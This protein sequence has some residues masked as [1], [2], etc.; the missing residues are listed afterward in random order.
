MNS[1]LKYTFT[2]PLGVWAIY[3]GEDNKYVSIAGEDVI[4][5]LPKIIEALNLHLSEDASVKF[6]DHAPLNVQQVLHEIDISI[7]NDEKGA[8]FVI[9]VIS[10]ILTFALL[11]DIIHH[12]AYDFSNMLHCYFDLTVLNFG[13]VRVSINMSYSALLNGVTVE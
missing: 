2:A 9:D 13:G 4:T 3:P 11:T 12:I 5:K 1:K 10:D 8:H 6:R 7:S